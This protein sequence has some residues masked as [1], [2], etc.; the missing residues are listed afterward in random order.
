MLP[1]AKL[2]KRQKKGIAFRERKHGKTK[3]SSLDI[4]GNLENETDV[5]SL[6][7]QVLVDA[8]QGQQ[9]HQVSAEALVGKGKAGAETEEAERRLVV[10]ARKRRRKVG[11]EEKGAI[12]ESDK[13]KPKRR[14][15]SDGSPI[16][17]MEQPVE[18]NVGA[19]ETGKE[20]EKTKQ[21]FILFLG[22]LKYT[23]TPEAI[24]VHF[25]V[26]VPPPT[27]RLLTPK[28][29]TKST[30]KPVIKSKGCA[31]LEFKHHGALQQGL[32]LHH[33]QLDGRQINVELTAGG[34]GKGLT[35]IKKLKERNKDLEGQ[36]QKRQDPKIQSNGTQRFSGTSGMEQTHTHN[37][38]WTIG[39]VEEKE[40]HRGGQKHQSG[41][42]KRG[43][44]VKDFRTGMNAIPIG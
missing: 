33:S 29:S 2:T 6:E 4:T 1:T 35:R 31:F 19:G 10:A 32:K 20:S 42:K 24:Q 22:N 25:S 12:G 41:S 7:D 21:R 27:V 8:T 17:G 36:R 34:G 5:Y 13:P 38:T 43:S 26:C 3:D 9:G 11:E 40:T 28:P 37:R 39:D 16:V 15:G 18:D 23:T 14:K 44:L 30:T